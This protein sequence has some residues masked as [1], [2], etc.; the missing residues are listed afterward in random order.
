MTL[1]LCCANVPLSSGF[2]LFELFP[3]SACL[4]VVILAIFAGEMWAV[5]SW[6]VGV[7]EGDGF[8][9]VFDNIVEYD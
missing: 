9:T 2:V 5:M 3:I 4:S 7:E 6:R 8:G 1:I